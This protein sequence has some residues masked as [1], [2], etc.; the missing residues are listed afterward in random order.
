MGPGVAML[1]PLP[2]RSAGPLRLH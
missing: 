2:R 1:R